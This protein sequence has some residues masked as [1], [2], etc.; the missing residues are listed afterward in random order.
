MLRNKI[1]LGSVRI[2]GSAD[3]HYKGV[4]IYSVRGGGVQFSEIALLIALM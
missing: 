3:Q 1:G 2:S 4:W